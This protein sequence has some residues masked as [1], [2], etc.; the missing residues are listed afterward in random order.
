LK[1][2]ADAVQAARVM[3]DVVHLAA[4]E[5][6]GSFLGGLLD[7]LAALV[8]HDAAGVY[9]MNRSGRRFKHTM[10][11]GCD[12]PPELDAALKGDGIIG[13]ALAS[14]MPVA[15]T[16]ETSDEVARGRPCAKSRLVLPIVGN[17]TKVLGAVDIWSDDTGGYDGEATALL[18][19]YSQAVAIAIEGSRLL[20]EVVDKRRL[21]NDLALARQVMEEL[22]PHATPSMPGFDIAGAHDPSFAVGG[23]Y[24]EFIP[25]GDDRWGVVV[26]D[27]VGKGIA[28]A[29]LVSA[30]RASI[31]TLVEHELAVRAVMR[32][33]N[34]F[35]HESI[36]E[37]RYVTLFYGVIEPSRRRMLYV[38]A[39]HVPPLLRRT[40]GEVEL[41]EEGGV[42]LGMF[43]APRY[44]EG[45]VALGEGDV[46][47]L[48]TDGVVETSD[49]T[50][51]FYGV[52][53]LVET[54]ASLSSRS[55][56]EICN[57]IMRDVR[58]HGGHLRRDDRT[59]VVMKAV[60]FATDE[61]APQA[62]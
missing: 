32:R 16:T 28:A 50:E 6:A 46:L 61:S 22:L 23:D 12:F 21:D 52:T 60:P 29:L 59:L 35:L 41:L 54:L 42:P 5:D 49:S 51:E 55:G 24:Y 43:E 48:Y 9:L 56:A 4:E 15:A 11:R 20:A 40:N 1:I 37:G 10:M 31:A 39:G 38:N 26:A 36:D 19:V 47:A 13:R 53:R 25:L 30:L 45:H 8:E 33:A 57:G 2:N 3:V 62:T 44:V 17:D 27:V 58:S 7:G 14:G 34:R 18:G